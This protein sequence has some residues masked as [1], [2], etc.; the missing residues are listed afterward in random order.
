MIRGL[1][2]T[3][4]KVEMKNCVILYEKEYFKIF[5]RTKYFLKLF[6]NK[7]RQSDRKLK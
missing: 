7:E 5:K 2:T 6:E 3:F 1:A 4:K